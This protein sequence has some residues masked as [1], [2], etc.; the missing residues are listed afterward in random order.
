LITF[1]SPLNK[2]LYFFVTKIKIRETLRSF[3]TQQLYGFRQEPEV[4][5]QDPI[6]LSLHGWL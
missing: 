1:G 5:R 2:V 3:I 4:L 6:A